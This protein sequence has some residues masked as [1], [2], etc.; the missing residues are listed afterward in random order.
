MQNVID[1][2]MLQ[3]DASRNRILDDF[4]FLCGD[5]FSCCEKTLL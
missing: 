2:S 3:V 5:M 4:Q 1:W